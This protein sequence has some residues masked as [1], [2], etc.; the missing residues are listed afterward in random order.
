MRP[1]EGIDPNTR[2]TY[3]SS[4]NGSSQNG[5]S[6]HANGSALGETSNGHHPN[7][8][9]DGTV[10]GMGGEELYYGVHNREEVTRILLQALSD[11]GYGTAAQ[12][13]SKE[14]GYALEV[15]SVAAFRAAVL[16]GRWSQSETLLLGSDTSSEDGGVL[17]SHERVESSRR[18]SR[19]EGVSSASTNGHSS[20]SSGLPLAAGADTTRLRFLL[21]QQK[22]LELLERRNLTAALSVLRT[23]L[24]PL[25]TDINRLHFLSSLVMC[26]T[27][28]DL[29]AQAEWDG[30]K[31]Q[32]RQHLLSEI[33][34]SISPSVMIPEHRLG[35]LLS[36]VQD[37]QVMN[38]RYHNTTA[39][40]SLYVDHQCS[41]DDFPLQTVMQLENHENQVWVLDFSPDGTMLATA[42]QDGVVCVYDTVR[43]RLKHEF[44][45]HR[46]PFSTSS[47]HDGSDSMF[48]VTHLAFSPDSQYL[49]SCSMTKDFVVTNVKTGA[50]V[51]DAHHFDQPVTS[52]AWLPNSESFVVGSQS[53][54]RPLG[55]Y[56]LRS[57]GASGSSP[58][59]IEDLVHSW[60]DSAWEGSSRHSHAPLRISGVAINPSGTRLAASTDDSRIKIFS[61]ESADQYRQ[62]DDWAMDSNIHSVN[63][64]KDGEL[65][66]SMRPGR[67]FTMDIETGDVV[68]TYEGSTQKEF[69][70]RSAFGGA[71][72]SFVISGSEGLLH[73]G[74]TFW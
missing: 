41:S 63:F 29:R 65:L 11:L 33:S 66:V 56:S 48:G 32:S 17:V 69:V 30:A 68:S 13:L 3:G 54:E 2:T 18:K 25:K 24:T 19:M 39:Q 38:C 36:A 15:P 7:G 21:R 40:P 49:L 74:D 62:L 52:A 60:R 27:A 12:Q 70:I 8:H 43:W 6:P 9:S 28:G 23:E 47:S 50:R 45:E 46:N 10:A 42:G 55:L 61:L 20:S 59:L 35:A 64:S 26:P 22:Y 67:I 44:R 58:T 57:A 5:S 73:Q 51:A 16:S 31:G 4:T 37:E 1:G 53:S 72:E 71:G 14:S 34:G